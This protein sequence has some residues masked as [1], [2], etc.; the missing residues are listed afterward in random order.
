MKL[1]D[2][3]LFGII[4][5]LLII[6]GLTIFICLYLIEDKNIYYECSKEISE[7]ENINITLKNNLEASEDGTVLKVNSEYIYK[8]ED[9]KTYNE[10][11]LYYEGL[12]DTEYNLDSELLEITVISNTNDYLTYDENEEIVDTW[13]KTYLINMEELEYTCNRK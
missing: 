4:T 3:I 2:K 5:F 13:Y 12:E 8:Y 11:K 7:E 9:T 6:I 1:R 10:A